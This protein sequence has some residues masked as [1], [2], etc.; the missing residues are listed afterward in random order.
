M[1]LP[2]DGVRADVSSVTPTRGATFLDEYER[3]DRR[4]PTGDRPD[5]SA[6]EETG[7]RI[8]AGNLA[9]LGI[10]PLEA[11][12]SDFATAVIPLVSLVDRAQARF[13]TRDTGWP[14]YKSLLQLRDLLCDSS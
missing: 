12:P 10:E 4:V 7:I 11:I 6:I 13:D 9:R 5:Q 1:V 14:L 3:F 8:L 2:R